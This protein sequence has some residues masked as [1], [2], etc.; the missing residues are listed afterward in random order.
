MRYIQSSFI[1]FTLL[2][3][4]APSAS[5]A[6]SSGNVTLNGEHV[7][8]LWFDIAQHAIERESDYCLVENEDWIRE[9]VIMYLL[10]Q[11]EFQP[12]NSALEPRRSDQLATLPLTDSQILKVA[13]N[14]ATLRIAGFLMRGKRRYLLKKLTE[15]LK[16]VSANSIKKF[17][18]KLKAEE[19]PAIVDAVYVKRRQLI[20]PKGE[21]S[22][23]VEQRLAKGADIIDL[24]ARFDPGFNH[25][26]EG[27]HWYLVKKPGL[28]PVPD[29]NPGNLHDRYPDWNRNVRNGEILGPIEGR[30]GSVSYIQVVGKVHRELVTL[31]KGL[32][33][34]PSHIKDW[35]RKHLEYKRLPKAK[36]ILR[37]Q[38]TVFA[39][40]K[41][42]HADESFYNCGRYYKRYIVH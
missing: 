29:M 34:D 6:V 4:L 35:I 9:Y 12:A 15:E 37:E 8:P 26:I 24:S 16:P 23:A 7:N 39:D 10:M 22:E 19:H 17:Y 14:P 40:N 38:A 36:K 2:L 30:N 11:Q 20:V 32:P 42:V 21:V 41:L 3:A 1:V 5:R 33:G 27:K 28:V 13:K 25:A 31:N 18:E